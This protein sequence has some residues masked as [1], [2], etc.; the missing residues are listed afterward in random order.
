M[1]MISRRAVLMGGVVLGAAAI[2]GSAILMSGDAIAS[3]ETGAAAPAFSLQDASGRMRTL[4][5]FAGRTVVLEWTNNGCP[6]VV[7][8]YSSGSMQATQQAATAAGVVVA[9]DTAHLSRTSK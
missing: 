2:A 4:S 3:V 6:Y 1:M 9:V 8:H 7:R 5:E